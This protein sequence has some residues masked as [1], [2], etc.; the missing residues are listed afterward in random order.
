M[1]LRMGEDTQATISLSLNSLLGFLHFFSYHFPLLVLMSLPYHH[2]RFH[3]S[4]AL[5]FFQPLVCS[6]CAPFS[7]LFNLLPG[8]SFPSPSCSLSLPPT[9]K[10]QR[11]LI[12]LTM[13]DA[14]RACSFFCLCTHTHVGVCVCVFVSFWGTGARTWRS[15]R[16][17]THVGPAKKKTK[18]RQVRP[19]QNKIK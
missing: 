10:L 4:T 13:Q 15:S 19:R 17:A 1:C 2:Y 3:F 11:Y 12:T 6:L 14:M 9:G 18:K 16:T 5:F 7:Y 8:V